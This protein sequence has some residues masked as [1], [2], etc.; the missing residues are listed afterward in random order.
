MAVRSPVSKGRSPEAWDL[1]A[2]RVVAKPYLDPLVAAA[3][4][5]AHLSLLERW[6]PPLDGMAVLKTDLWE[7][8]I[9][10]DELLFTLAR[11]AGSATGVDISPRV[12]AAARER[13]AVPGVELRLAE[14]DLLEGLPFA[15]GEF[16]AVVSTSTIDHLDS[17]HEHRFALAE[18]RRVLV[19]GGTLVVTVDNRDNAFDWLLRAANSLGGVPFPLREGPTLD[20][21]RELVVDAGFRAEEH[22]YLVPAPRVLATAAVRLAR[23]LPDRAAER[24]VSGLLR[25]FDALGQRAPRRLGS[26]VALRALAI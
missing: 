17:G 24:A 15:A 11:R 19:D 20:E 21:L 5:R 2:E 8:G 16:D 4:R 1:A 18:L 26:F 10:G 23:R 25:S 22:E 3:K 6:L 14:A 13:A 9:G 12:V 7:E